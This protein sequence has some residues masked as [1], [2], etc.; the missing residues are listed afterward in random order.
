MKKFTIPFYTVHENL[1]ALKKGE[2][3]FM[4]SRDYNNGR[5]DDWWF[6]APEDCFLVVP[7][8]WFYD[9]NGNEWIA[10]TMKATISIWQESMNSD[11]KMAIVVNTEGQRVVAPRLYNPYWLGR[12][13]MPDQNGELWTLPERAEYL[14]WQRD[15]NTA[16]EELYKCVEILRKMGDN[17]VVTHLTT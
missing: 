6:I 8:I 5:C 9:R 1:I 4:K 7:S 17:I 2:E 13:G 12:E 10:R 15:K 3:V 14:K 11:A 16:Y